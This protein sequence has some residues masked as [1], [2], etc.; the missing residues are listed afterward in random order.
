MSWTRILERLEDLK[1]DIE[2]IAKGQ[3]RVEG[4]VNEIRRS[5]ALAGPESKPSQPHF[6]GAVGDHLG[7]HDC[8]TRSIPPLKG[9]ATPTERA[10][11]SFRFDGR[12]KGNDNTRPSRSSYY[13]EGSEDNGKTPLSG[14]ERRG[15]M[16]QQREELHSASNRY[17]TIHSGFISSSLSHSPSSLEASRCT[18][19]H[20]DSSRRVFFD[21][22][23]LV[24][25]TYDSVMI[26]YELAWTVPFEGWVIVFTWVTF[27]FWLSDLMLGFV[28]G[29]RQNGKLVMD[30][31]R[32][33]RKYVTTYFFPNLL[34]VGA[35]FLGIMVETTAA[36]GAAGET[37]MLVKSARIIKLNRMLRLAAMFRTGQI[38]QLYDR[39]LASMRKR[40]IA[41][42]MDILVKSTKLVILIIWVNHLGGC[43]WHL[44]GTTAR[45]QWYTTNFVA[46][47]DSLEY[48]L[49]FYW[50]TSA[51]IAGESVMVP[52]GAYELL[53]SICFVLFGFIFSSVLISSLATTLINFQ[54][55]N[56]EQQ[57]KLNTLRQFLYQH[58]VDSTLC[59]PIEKQVLARMS[60][61]KR[62][63]QKDVG[64]L[65][66]LSPMMRTELLHAIYG[67]S[68]LSLQFNAVCAEVEPTFVKNV[69]FHVLVHEAH[70]PGDRIF[71]P[72]M[73]AVGAFYVYWGSLE[74]LK[75]AGL[76]SGASFSEQAIAVKP[77]AVQKGRW[78]SEIS[79]WSCWKH[80][81]WMDA[82]APC[83][84]LTMPSDSFIEVLQSHP[85]LAVMGQDYS[86]ALVQASSRKLEEELL[87][88]INLTTAHE[89]V[90]LSMQQLPR[91]LM[92]MAAISALDAAHGRQARYSHDTVISE[93]RR[94]VEE[95]QCDVVLYPGERFV[96]LVGQV[97]L[98]LSHQDSCV[99][100][101]LGRWDGTSA[102]PDCALPHTQ[103]RVGEPPR[104]A[105]DRLVSE[106]VP[107][108]AQGDVERSI[109]QDILIEEKVWSGGVVSTKCAR[110]LFNAMADTDFE[111]PLI[112]LERKQ[113][114]APD[115]DHKAFMVASK[116]SPK[117]CVIYSWLPPSEFARLTAGHAGEALVQR[118]LSD[119][120]LD[121]KKTNLM[122]P[123]VNV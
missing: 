94:E 98:R 30:F 79:L 18:A 56:K 24:V 49:A 31:K 113:D 119:F 19:L 90:L 89:A 62:L 105:L 88:D 25:L 74:Y 57:D 33:Y 86:A 52:T 50:S 6:E 54:M 81:G 66:L 82:T 29:F 12:E 75:A 116:M 96:R 45:E 122:P 44:I 84:L 65:S 4:I 78:V 61:V 80:R 121:D 93:L 110:I 70:E 120:D 39:V 34:L 111:T 103:I 112:Y 55:A 123:S 36:R 99:L 20:P 46:D 67:R 1:A 5:N 77:E 10:T 117:Q 100:T 109:E 9:D 27:L 71:R 23:M 64:A 63:C 38:A 15:S 108:V 26:P 2:G 42:H 35:D 41:E 60:N 43:M 8:S 85:E 69:C 115:S 102:T 76:T 104:E 13:S 14:G 87:S 47:S 106:W 21:I 95:Q 28:T 11:T 91:R 3:H 97:V 22:T 32:I 51:M 101:Q 114:A 40:G 72:G 37:A 73:E 83:E 118:I 48:L 107:F 53:C 58:Q 17:S 16:L 68:V 59:V 92:S 7:V